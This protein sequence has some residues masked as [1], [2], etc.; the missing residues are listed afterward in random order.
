VLIYPKDGIVTADYPFMLINPAKR[1]AYSKVTAYL[2]DKP[3]QQAMA[4]TTLRRPVNPD[5]P[6]AGPTSQAL[7]ELPFPAR[8]AVVDAIL[9]SFDNALRL[10][11]DS[12]F[13][14]DESGSMY[15][16][17]IN[18]LRSAMVGLSGADQSISGRFARFRHRERIFLL[19]FSSEPE[20]LQEFEMGTDA[21]SNQVILARVRERV[22]ALHANG[23]TAIYDALKV[24]YLAAIARRHEDP[25]RFYSIVLMTD[26]K[27]S[28]GSDLNSFIAW[29]GALPE[30]DRG[31]K[32]FPIVFGEADQREMV[33]LADLTGGRAFDSRK[34]SLQ[35]IFKE[36]RGYQ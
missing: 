32:L 20:P 17:R 24:A 3:F 21:Q 18:D 6:V 1:D 12:T 14:L 5:V 34:A 26:G 10:P 28:A 8:L 33:R 9:A 35:S 22:D 13:V 29:Y 7:V 2:R 16:A 11:T 31:I 19:P 30:R 15:G 27:N 25:A 23:G 36:V 4:T